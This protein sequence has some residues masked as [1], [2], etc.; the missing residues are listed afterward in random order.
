MNTVILNGVNSNTITGLL[1]QSL[2][3][4]SKPQMRVEVEEIDGRDGDV[5][6]KLGYA[7]YEKE[8]EIG[9][10]G[11]FDI[12]E[13]I[14]FFST[15]GEVIFSNEPDKIYRYALYD[16]IDYE[17]LIRFRTATVTFHV[18]PFK[19]STEADQTITSS[20]ATVTNSGNVES[21]PS[22]TI[23]GSGTINFSLNGTQ[24]FVIVMGTQTSITIN[25]ETLEAYSGEILMNRA[26]TGD[27]ANLRLSPGAN[28][29]SW[30]GTVTKIVIH[31]RSR[32]I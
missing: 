17:R 3:S 14:G 30:T 32:W 5:V 31:N 27:Y 15:E 26:V 20:G 18:Q 2:P 1:I 28:T 19:Y 4:I 8:M 13:V 24:I 21:K 22:I 7:A 29:F 10:H 25:A 11:N 23:T 9:L 12:N 6:T 16:Q